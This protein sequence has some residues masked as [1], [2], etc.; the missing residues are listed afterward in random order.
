ME[1]RLR[2]KGQSRQEKEVGQTDGC[3]EGVLD[4][5]VSEGNSLRVEILR[6]G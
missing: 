4:V 1:S 6:T 2:R 5:G 3:D